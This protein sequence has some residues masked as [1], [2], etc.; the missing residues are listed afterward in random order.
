MSRYVTKHFGLYEFLPKRLY[1]DLIKRNKEHIGWG[2]IDVRILWTMDNIRELYG[3]TFINTWYFGGSMQWRGLR[4]SDNKYFSQT[5]QHSFG[6]ATD[7]NSDNAPAQ[8]IRDDILLN[9]D[10]KEFQFINAI[11]QDVT[12]LHASCENMERVYSIYP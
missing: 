5:S 11:E 4:T 6:R 9:P 1:L 7:S 10:R 8:Q 3:P 12:W 2:L